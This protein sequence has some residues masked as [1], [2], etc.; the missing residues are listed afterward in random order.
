MIAH[1]LRNVGKKLSPCRL[2]VQ[3]DVIAALQ[4]HE[5][6]IGYG[7]GHKAAFGERH[8]A[9]LRACSTSVGLRTSANRS[10]TSIASKPRIRPTAFSAE[11]NIRYKSE[12]QRYYSG[13]LSGMNTAV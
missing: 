8:P 6:C 10:V 5:F 3:Q 1:K 7:A 12:N 11:V 2:V 9:S 13:L 4:R